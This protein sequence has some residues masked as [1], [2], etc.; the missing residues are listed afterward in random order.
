MSGEYDITF[1][2]GLMGPNAGASFSFGVDAGG[3]LTLTKET[4]FKRAFN[5]TTHVVMADGT[6][7]PKC[8]ADRAYIH[9]IID[10]WLDDAP[11]TLG[12]SQLTK[13][14]GL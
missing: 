3:R 1:L 8:E 5:D 12:S 7:K 10:C 11:I 13:E 14:Q 6:S 9:Y 4:A 2:H